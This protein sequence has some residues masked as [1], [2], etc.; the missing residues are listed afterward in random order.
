MYIMGIG[1]RRIP[2]NVQLVTHVLCSLR[3]IEISRVVFN[4]R[5]WYIKLHILTGR[6]SNIHELLSFSRCHFFLFVSRILKQVV[7]HNHSR[8]DY[9]VINLIIQVAFSIATI[10]NRYYTINFF[11]WC[12]S[13]IRFP[14]CFWIELLSLNK[15]LFKNIHHFI[16]LIR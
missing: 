2:F 4:F 15:R 1:L 12:L 3:K 13:N 6:I 11:K 8:I 10:H 14:C 9:I 7:V 16:A 5:I